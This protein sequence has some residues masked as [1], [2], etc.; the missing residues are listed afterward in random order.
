MSSALPMKV[1]LN[2][3]ALLSPL[4]GIGYYVYH[5]A[6]AL[7][8]REDV[9]MRLFYRGAFS[10]EVQAPSSQTTSR[11]RPL[12]RRYV[13]NAYGVARILRER[14][15][16]HALRKEPVDL[17]HE[18]S[19]LSLPYA[20]PTVVTVH[21]LSWLRFPETHPAERVKAMERWFEPALRGAA[22]LLTDSE[23]VRQEVIQTFGVDPQ[24]VVSVP[25]GLDPIFRPRDPSAMGGIL[26]SLRLPMGRYLLAVGTLEP[27]KNVKTT[28]EAYASLPPAWRSRNPLVFAGLRGW[29]DSQLMPLLNPMIQSGEVRLLGY[30]EREQL[31]AVTA[32]ARAMVYPSLYEGFGLP[33]LEAMGC[34]VPPIVSRDTCLPEVVGNAGLTVPALDSKALADAMREL[35]EDDALRARLS[36]EALSRASAFTWE[37]CAEQT[38]AVYRRAL[39]RR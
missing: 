5:L 29:H 31:A 12:V 19:Y 37:Q 7:Q 14:R 2:A 10:S 9:A 15:F 38:T 11:L 28:L 25:L 27:R 36:R 17:Y 35:S 13:P 4:T 34:G 21:D 6:K 24:T 3:R 8:A 23:Y 20:G 30:L 32:G 39:S 1:V 16:A 18:P 26:E 22:M 33:P